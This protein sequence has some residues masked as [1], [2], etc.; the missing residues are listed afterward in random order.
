MVVAGFQATSLVE[1]TRCCPV[2]RASACSCLARPDSDCLSEWP[3]SAGEARL[4]TLYDAICL[5]RLPGQKR[6]V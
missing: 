2:Q 5:E 1:V 4:S 3:R 6:S